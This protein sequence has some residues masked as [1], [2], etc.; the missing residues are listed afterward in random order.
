MANNF[1]GLLTEGGEGLSSGERLIF[2]SIL[3]P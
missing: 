2:L 1:P 3:L